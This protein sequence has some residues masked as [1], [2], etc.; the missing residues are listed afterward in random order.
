MINV[1]C[2]I[3][4]TFICNRLFTLTKVSIPAIVS[5]SF[6]NNSLI[7]FSAEFSKLSLFTN[8]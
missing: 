8:A 4:N 6:L 1:E 2:I 3:K 7:A 5:V